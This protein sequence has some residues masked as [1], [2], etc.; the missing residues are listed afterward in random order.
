LGPGRDDTEQTSELV[1]GLDRL[2]EVQ[3]GGEEEGAEVEED[4]FEEDEVRDVKIFASLEV[5]V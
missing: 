4:E 1:A 3:G 2:L 5:N